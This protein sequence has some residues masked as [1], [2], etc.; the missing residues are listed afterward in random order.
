V[1]ASH[2]NAKALCDHPRNLTD[3]QFLALVKNGGCAGLN[4]CPDF[5]GQG[6][7]IEAVIAHAD[8]FLSLGG[9]K[10][11]CLGGDL[12]GIGS[13]PAGLRG[14]Q[15]LGVLYEAMLRRNWSEKLVQDI[16]YHNLMRFMEAAL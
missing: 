13:L 15:D 11:L 5:L 8:H 6:R 16:F 14:V 9:Q 7:G 3:A 4:L 10:S 2:S 1:L 12:D